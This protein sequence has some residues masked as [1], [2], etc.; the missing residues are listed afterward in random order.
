MDAIDI[1]GHHLVLLF[2]H[3]KKGRPE[4][5]FDKSPQYKER[6]EILSHHIRI[7]DDL[8]YICL[9]CPESD[10]GENKCKKYQNTELVELDRELANEAGLEI[11]KTYFSSELKNILKNLSEL[12]TCKTYSGK[13][14]IAIRYGR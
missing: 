14:L 3:L 6:E 5:P 13:S 11:G 4:H 8:D 10:K 9:N 1:R 12:G 7:I 2:E